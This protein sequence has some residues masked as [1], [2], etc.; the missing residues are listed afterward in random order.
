MLVGMVPFSGIDVGLNRG[1]PV[2]C[3]LYQRHG[4][5]P[6]SGDLRAATWLPGPVADYD[7]AQVLQ[8]EIETALF[9]D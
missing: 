6:H 4:S 7:P 3:E 1:G 2:D 5:F 8:A 9:Y